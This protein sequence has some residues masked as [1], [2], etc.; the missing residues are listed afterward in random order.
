MGYQKE[1]ANTVH[2][3]G[4]SKILPNSAQKQLDFKIS[5]VKFPA[6]HYFCYEH[7]IWWEKLFVASLYYDP[8][9]VST[10]KILGYT[11]KAYAHSIMLVSGLGQF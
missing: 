9:N 10:S 6:M 5:V 2:S 11:S 4:V 7:K 8:Q 1:Q 3:R